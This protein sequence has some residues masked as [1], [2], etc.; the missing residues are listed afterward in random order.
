MCFLKDQHI[1]FRCWDEKKKCW[2]C[3]F[4]MG[5]NGNKFSRRGHDEEKWNEEGKRE[6]HL[7]FFFLVHVACMKK[8]PFESVRF[9]PLSHILISFRIQWRQR[10]RR[11]CCNFWDFLQASTLIH[12]LTCN[13][14]SYDTK[15]NYPDQIIGGG[16]YFSPIIRNMGCWK[17][18]EAHTLSSGSHSRHAHSRVSVCTWNNV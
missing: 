4:A 8:R 15:L 13:S 17:A 12:I 7:H 18:Q 6:A 1:N 9:P 11:G 5:Y 14:T 2:R 3:L 16:F 10:R